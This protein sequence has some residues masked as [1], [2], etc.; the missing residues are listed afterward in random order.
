MKRAYAFLALLGLTVAAAGC[1]GSGSSGS[2]SMTGPS[3]SM[4]GTVQVRLSRPSARQDRLN[5]NAQS[6]T[7]ETVPGTSPSGAADAVTTVNLP[8][9]GQST[10]AV[11]TGVPVGQHVVDVTSFSG[12]NGTGNVLDTGHSDPVQVTA[13][14][15]SNV[16]V[17]VS[18]GV[19]LPPT[20]N[21]QAIALLARPESASPNGG[22]D[23]SLITGLDTAT[24][25]V[26]PTP[27]NTQLGSIDVLAATD[28]GSVDVADGEDSLCVIT[29]VDKGAIAVGT[30][31]TSPDGGA[32][33]GVMLNNDDKTG[34]LAGAD[35]VHLLTG[36][37]ASPTIGLALDGGFRTGND[38]MVFSEDKTTAI[39]GSAGHGFSA[40]SGTATLQVI[41][42]ANTSTPVA[43][44]TITLPAQANGYEGKAGLSVSPADPTR[45]VV[46]VSNGLVLITGL[47]TNTPTVG[48]IVPMP[49]L[50]SGDQVI[51]ATVTRDGKRVA[52]LTFQGLQIFSGV[53][54]GTLTPV[55]NFLTLDATGASESG[56]HALQ[57]ALD[58]SAV[59]VV[60]NQTQS[61]F[62][63]TG[64]QGTTLTLS[65][66]L[67]LQ[68][69]EVGRQDDDSL[70]L[71]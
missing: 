14:Q 32:A 47:D 4:T 64:F 31:I 28:D 43:G 49:A 25:T 50:A 71:H 38:S 34:L 48:S 40:G 17:T 57:F 23:L 69:S 27:I 46:P 7:V 19:N 2:M 9:P 36:L 68:P 3:T 45:M 44:P 20:F 5:A 65:T 70:L 66:T 62:I 53:D 24:P 37:P 13:G 15:T 39:I 60:D 1:G 22:T 6:V 56:C 26:D 11:V 8:A 35:G 42:S 55:S 18:G 33:S 51:S 16:T 41:R 58:N 52:A 63:V 21:F 59:Y 10:L 30:P 67:T 54:T 61:F 12:P 29:G